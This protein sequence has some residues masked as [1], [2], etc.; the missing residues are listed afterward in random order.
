MSAVD[1]VLHEVVS[2]ALIERVLEYSDAVV[3]HPAFDVASL[4][5]SIRGDMRV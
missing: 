2:I 3:L 1:T 4:V 5:V